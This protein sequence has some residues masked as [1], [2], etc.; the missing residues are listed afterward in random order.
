MT[1]AGNLQALRRS[2]WLVLLVT[3]VA[4]A[5]ATAITVTAPPRYATATTFF[6]TTPGEERADV[7]QGSVFSRERIKSYV[8]VVGGERLAGMVAERYPLGLSIQQI[9]DRIS[10]QAIRDTVLFTVT[11]T[12]TDEARS[13][14]LARAVL[15][16]FTALVEALEGSP[17]LDLPAVKLEVVAG[18]SPAPLAAGTVRNIGLGLLAGLLVG[19]ALALLRAAFDRAIRTPERLQQAAMVPLL[20]VVPH[21]AAMA[22]RPALSRD[23]SGGRGPESFRHLRTSLRAVAPELRVLAVASAASRDGRSITAAN[24]AISVAE[25]GR[26]VLLV[27]ADLRRPRLADYLGLAPGPG[28][29][30][31]LAGRVAARDALQQW[32]R[33]PVSVL[34]AGPAAP[35][36]SELLESPRWSELLAWARRDFDL[37]VIDTPPLLPVTDAAV[38]AAGADGVLLVARTNRTGHDQVEAAT[39]LLWTVHAPVVGCVLT[40]M[41]RRDRRLSY[42][43]PIVQRHAERPAVTSEAVPVTPQ[44]RGLAGQPTAS[45]R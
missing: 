21:Q 35:N 24:L 4:V 40:D 36:P 29:S 37:V 39:A 13:Q 22:R 25:T 5:A 16:E 23:R 34:P 44:T 26:R 20:A 31:V 11:V 18:P 12:D 32:R 15:I 1:I 41:R 10:A 38:V 45:V 33:Q 6:V 14:Q 3:C 43:Y 42:R 17:A 9:Q 30:D 19:V 8:D 2:W 27:D 28:L 7:M